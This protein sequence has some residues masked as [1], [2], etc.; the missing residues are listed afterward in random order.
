M[1]HYTDAYYI[2]DAVFQ[3]LGIPEDMSKQFT[4]DE[5]ARNFHKQYKEDY[6]R[7]LVEAEIANYDTSDNV[8]TDI[9]DTIEDAVD[10]VFQRISFIEDEYYMNQQAL[11]RN[12]YAEIIKVLQ[13]TAFQNIV[14]VD[15]EYEPADPDVGIFNEERYINFKL[16]NGKYITF[17]VEFED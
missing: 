5:Q 8:E 9:E 12:A 6:I 3:R 2:A 10:E 16:S 17:T 1:L 11:F 4:T 7:S 13:N 15:S 14:D